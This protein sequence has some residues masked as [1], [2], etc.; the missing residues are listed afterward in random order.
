MKESIFLVIGLGTFGLETSLELT[1]KGANVIAV[2]TRP[3]IIEKIK[4]SVTQALLLD[5]TKE[6][7][8]S[9][10]PIENI[11][12]AIIAIGDNIEAN[13]LTTALL[14]KS[15]IPYIISRA[16]GELHHRVL[17][18]VGANEI[19]DIERT[20]GK[21]LA[22]KIISP[23]VLDSVP[24]TMSISIAE[25]YLP[26]SFIGK[27][28]KEI[29]TEGKM[30][31]KVSAIKRENVTINEDGEAEPLEEIVFPENETI[32]EEGDILIIIGQNTDIEEMRE[33]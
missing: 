19:I 22:E 17:K 14:K 15:G 16:T 31:L 3:E 5:S 6:E 9:K 28:L 30:N 33:L 2:D 23:F 1:E 12:V 29:D 8:L 24:L 18:Q 7:H 21:Q 25:V 13:I 26:D 27:N 32:F 20:A 10:L 11:K 4:D